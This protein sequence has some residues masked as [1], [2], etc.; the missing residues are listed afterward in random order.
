M[1]WFGWT[2]LLLN[3]GAIVLSGVYFFAFLFI[4]NDYLVDV[5]IACFGASCGLLALW[6]LFFSAGCFDSDDSMSFPLLHTA[7]SPG[8]RQLPCT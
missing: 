6:C 1:E 4:D 8:F 2:T 3:V 7:T 5:S